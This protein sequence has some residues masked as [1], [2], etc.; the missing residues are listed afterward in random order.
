MGNQ[1]APG[2]HASSYDEIKPLI[3]LCQAGRLFDVQT[4]ISNGNPVNLPVPQEKGA[5]KKGPLEVA[6]ESGFH[7][8]VQVLLEGGAETENS[9]YCALD[10]A[11][12]KKR[13]DLM[14]LLI[15]HGA[16]IN[17][18]SMGSVFASWEPAIMEFFLDNG[19]DV[20]TGNP[21]A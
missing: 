8:L 15:E 1:T 11:L 19:A 16:G 2:R 13:L 21:M 3:A 6:I 9:R 10:H 12:G 7:S 20:E 5:R 14:E 4:W 18:V 17:S